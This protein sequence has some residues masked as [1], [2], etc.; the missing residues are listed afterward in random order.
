MFLILLKASRFY[1]EFLFFF[2]SVFFLTKTFQ[3]GCPSLNFQDRNKLEHLACLLYLCL[4]Y[5]LLQ[6]ATVYNY[7]FHKIYKHMILFIIS[8]KL[9]LPNV[10]IKKYRQ[11][12]S[13]M[14]V[15]II[16]I[17]KSLFKKILF[18]LQFSYKC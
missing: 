6:Q 7:I 17:I 4:T 2:N 15:N 10:I 18:I 3:L 16:T 13:V 9:I 8:I 5:L 11:D 1:I 14:F 12:I